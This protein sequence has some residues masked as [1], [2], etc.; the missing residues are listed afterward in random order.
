MQLYVD[1][2]PVSIAVDSSTL[3]EEFLRRIQR[4]VCKTGHIVHSLRCDGLPIASNQMANVLD[5]PI[6]AFHR[7]DVTTGTTGMLV[8]EA[9]VQAGAAL[10]ETEERSRQAAQFLMEGKAGEGVDALRECISAWQQIHDA[11]VKSIAMMELNTETLR[12][13]GQPVG[14]VVSK[15]RDALLQVRQALLNN[16]FVLLAD[17]LQYEFDDATQQWHALINSVRKEAQQQLDAAR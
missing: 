10:G 15:P 7:L 11:V 4:E 16:D 9:M 5:R 8:V 2:Q 6:S 12:I 17:L 14:E 13:E 3:L 1:D